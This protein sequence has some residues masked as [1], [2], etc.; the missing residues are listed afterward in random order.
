[1]AIHLSDLGMLCVGDLTFVSYERRA[2]VV[3]VSI[4]L[5]FFLDHHDRR[6]S[7]MRWGELE[8]DK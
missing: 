2:V 6:Q 1:M 7:P 4:V 5:S 3:P 8:G